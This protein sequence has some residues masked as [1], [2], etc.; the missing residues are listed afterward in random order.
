MARRNDTI[1]LLSHS[2]VIGLSGFKLTV[3][4]EWSWKF[5]PEFFSL[6]MVQIMICGVYELIA[7]FEAIKS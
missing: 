2:G 5:K 6:R 1:K 4:A 7:T 3:L